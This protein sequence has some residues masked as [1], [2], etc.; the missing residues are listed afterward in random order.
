LANQPRDVLTAFA[1]RWRLDPSMFEALQQLGDDPLIV[2]GTIARSNWAYDHMVKSWTSA[3]NCLNPNFPIPNDPGEAGLEA[4]WH[5]GQLP[6]HQRA[7]ERPV[8][9]ATVTNAVKTVS[10]GVRGG[11]PSTEET[12]FET[13]GRGAVHNNERTRAGE[14]LGGPIQQAFDRISVIAIAGQVNDPR[15]MLASRAWLPTEEHAALSGNRLLET[16]GQLLHRRRLDRSQPPGTRAHG[17][18]VFAHASYRMLRQP[19]RLA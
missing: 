9:R 16:L 3:V 11:K 18:L 7:S 19:L 8:Q 4:G 15:E 6:D 17:A 12:N 10:T 13:V 14:A 1:Q 5:I 2:C